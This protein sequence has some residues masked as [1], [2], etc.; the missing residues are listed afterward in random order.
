MSQEVLPFL[1]GLIPLFLSYTVEGAG[2]FLVSRDVPTDG[3]QGLTTVSLLGVGVPRRSHCSET[4][5]S[6]GMRHY[7]KLATEPIAITVWRAEGMVAS[8]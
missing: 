2:G 6:A 7:Y 8:K 3:L 5:G 1:C 4:G